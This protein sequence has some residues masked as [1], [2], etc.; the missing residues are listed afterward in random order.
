MPSIVIP[1][2][3]PVVMAASS[4][5]R[6]WIEHTPVTYYDSL[7]GND[8]VLIERIRDFDTV[9][10]IRSS[11]KFTSAVFDA[12]PRLKLLSIW[13]TG[14]DN[15]DL[16]AAARHGVT[17]TNT[18]GVS[19]V[20][21]AEHALMLTLAVA[22]HVTTIHNGVVSGAWPR[23]Q[24]MQLHGK[25]MG[26]IGLG[27]IGRQFARL[28]QGIG[29]RVIAW[30]MHPNPALGFELVDFNE[31]LRSSDVVSL[32]LRLSPETTGFLGRAQLE[33]MK[34]SSILINT[35]RG[36]I[37]DESALIESLQN[38]RIAGAGLDVFDVEPL[39]AGH[40]LTKLDN[41]V[42]TSHCAGITPEVLEAGLSLAIENVRSFFSGNPQNVVVPATK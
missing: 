41:V 9:I 17:V 28:A 25:A 32:H 4:A 26:V 31:L 22:R 35:A 30:T 39:P 29:M 2:D 37:V 8:E 3:Y 34:P 1:D 23:G 15:I 33:M 18:P 14:T 27:A 21:I 12:C 42:L 38:H 6:K 13:G 20:S 7:P 24:S 5:Y 36:P 16:P 19:A 40:P 11:C 10:N